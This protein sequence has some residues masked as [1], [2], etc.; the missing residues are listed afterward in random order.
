MEQNLDTSFS[1]KSRLSKENDV[2]TLVKELTIS[3]LALLV[4]LMA[5]SCMQKK[6]Q[7][8][9]KTDRFTK[10]DSLFQ[11]NHDNGQFNGSVLV[12][13][14]DSTIYESSFGYTDGT[15]AQ[16][17]DRTFRF[18]MGS[19]YKEFPAVAIMQLIENGR[20]G[21]EDN[22]QLYLPELPDWSQQISIKHLLQYTSGLP[23]INWM[24]HDSINDQDVLADLLALKALLSKPG[25]AYLYTNNSPFLLIKIVE[26]ITNMNFKEYAQL[27]LFTPFGLENTLIKERYPFV[28][29]SLMAIPF[30]TNGQEDTFPIHLSSIL[31]CSTPNDMYR[32]FEKLHSFEI[33]SE[34]SLLTLSQKSS[35]PA[36]NVQSPLGSTH[37]NGS[38]ITEHAHHGSSGNY[39][40]LISRYNNLDLTIVLMTNQKHGKLQALTEAVKGMVVDQ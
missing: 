19:I 5:G 37:V 14:E 18:N 35:S 12:V 4:L 26:Q 2:K 11:S 8:S 30:D 3:I 13:K 34:K 6:Q 39:E 10:I 36:D 38:M 33:I 31:V 32:W 16:Q 20:L 25:E 29:R 7:L 40:A 24:K 9:I 23:R 28:D 27:H 17:L 22:V 21:L 15:K 1:R